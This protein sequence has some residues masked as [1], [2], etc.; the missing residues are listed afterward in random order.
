MTVVMYDLV[1]A[2]DRRFSPF[3]WRARMAIAH[4]GLD[5]ETRP[6]RFTEIAGIVDGGQRSV[7]VLEDGDRVVADSWAIAEYLEDSYP[8]L[9]SLFRGEGGRRLARFVKY[10]VEASVQPV[11]V[12]MV[13]GD[14]YQHL[15]PSDQAYFRRS[16]EAR[17]G[18]S[19]E[20]VQVGR[21]A[22][23]ASL[24]EILTPLRLALGGQ[25][26]LGG[27]APF[28]AD[29]I[30]FG[31]FQ[32]PRVISDFEILLDDDPILDWLERCLDLYG[33]LGRAMPAAA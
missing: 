14:I 24:A 1:G 25:D 23:R 29:Y 8:D 3:C 33:G 15:E 22:R 5:C 10:W 11:I 20:A 6:T 32:W 12:R 18:D 2:D 26:Y 27:E 7:P 21:E 30:A 13:V 9:P 19:L 16:R 31:A 17:F 4:K 28:F